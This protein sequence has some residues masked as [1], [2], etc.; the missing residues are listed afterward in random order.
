MSI[1][2]NDPYNQAAKPEPDPRDAPIP[3]DPNIRQASGLTVREISDD[4]W[5]AA[6][7]EHEARKLAKNVGIS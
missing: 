1:N 6:L 3:W 5:Q 7:L 2:R 4:E